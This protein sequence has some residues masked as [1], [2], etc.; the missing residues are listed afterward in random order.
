MRKFILALFLLFVHNSFSQC[1]TTNA[2]SCVCEDGTSNCLLLPDITASWFSISNNGYIE[3]PQSGA[4][5]NY[6]GQGPDNGRL[7]VSASTPNIGHGPFIIRGINDSGT[8]T[9][10]CGNDTIFNVPEMGLFTCPNGFEEPLQLISQRI[11]AKNG[12]TMSYTDNYAGSV[13]YHAE[14]DHNHVDNWALISLRIPTADPNPLNWP[15]IGTSSKIVFCIA[16]YGQCGVSGSTY[17]GFCR[18]DNTV[19]LGGNT[20]YNVDFPNWNLG[21][22]SLTCT[23]VEQGISSGWTDV[24]AKYL[25]GMWVNIPPNTCNGDYYIVL[26]VDKSNYFVEEDEDNNWTAVPITLS[27]QL[28]AGTAVAPSITSDNSNNLCDGQSVTLT[29][30]AGTTFL[31]STGETSQSITTSTPGAYTCQV[32]NYCGT[33]I[34]EP[35]VLNSISSGIPTTIGD[36]V[37][38]SGELNLSATSTGE[39]T[40]Y[41]MDG[42]YVGNGNNFTTPNLTSSTTYFVQNTDSYYDTIFSAP[43]TNGFGSGAYLNTEEYETFNTH[44]ELIL[45]SVLVY[46]QMAGNLTIELQHDDGD[47][48]Y[49]TNVGLLA[50]ENRVILDFDIEMDSNLR[51]VGK[52]ITTGGIFSNNNGVTYSYELPNILSITGASN[53]A[54]NYNYFYDW[55]ILTL[56]STCSSSMIPVQAVVETCAS[57]GENISF[58]RSIKIIPN[59]N[60]GDF[61]IEFETEQSGTMKVKLISIIG[62]E[63]YSKDLEHQY[64]KNSF[65]IDKQTLSKGV[66]F[67]SICFEGKD[68][69][70]KIIIE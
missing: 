62:Q 11:Y 27:L 69:V 70:S 25:D 33:N 40:W 52:D 21:G 43:H 6:A 50:G 8:R 49:S 2:S 39:I 68:Y 47:V 53:G 32:T 45:R 31:W 29:A 42:I 4:G 56:N 17:E 48:I 18:D 38:V 64:G 14:H 51:L 23:Y 24:Y 1:T 66:Y 34:S 63:V 54:T 35:F 13:T 36:T 37:C 65:G 10:L 12:N 3:Y 20:L 67:I 57:I 26:E 58:K 5:T 22:G 9:F 30:S 61:L 60:N 19:Y 7:R 15:I 44:T 28:P 46:A 59:P 16:D 41:D 55:E